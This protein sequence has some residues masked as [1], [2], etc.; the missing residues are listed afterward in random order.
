MRPWVKFFTLKAVF[1]RYF[2]EVFMKGYGVIKTGQP[3][4]LDKEKPVPGPLDAIIRPT[5]LAPCSSDTHAMHGGAGPRENLILGHEA[6]GEVVETGGLVRKFKPGDTVV[7]PCVTPDWTG[8]YIQEGKYNAHDNARMGSFK[9]LSSK[10]GTFAEFFHVNMADANLVPL[11]PGIAPEAALMTVDMMSTGFHAVELA[12]AGYGETIVVI[13]IGPVGL[14]AVAGAQLK[15]AGRIIA[16]GTRP[17]C[18]KIAREYGATDIVSYKDGDIVTQIKDLSGGSV[19]KVI[20]AGGSA[21]TLTQAISMVK[22]TGIVSSVN[23][24]DASDTFTIP[25]P[26]WGLGMANIDIRGGFCPGG[27]VRIEKLLNLIKY[28]RIDAA[29]LITHRFDGFE[30][31]EEAFLLM[32]K[33]P[34]DLIKPA[35]FIKW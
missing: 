2:K 12:E 7:V 30:K 17:N 28:G 21:A 19:D 20:I 32:D 27:A 23:Y 10:D 26:A 9:F 14:M 15:G 6:V 22:P 16:V 5:A 34:A 31:I 1:K 11:P 25:A 18:V 29:K 33:K 8:R 35:V 3:G 24:Y 13:G 4:W